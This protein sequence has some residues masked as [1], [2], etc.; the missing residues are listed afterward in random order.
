MKKKN[1]EEKTKTKPASKKTDNKKPAAPRKTRKKKTA[2][3][4]SFNEVLEIIEVSERTL[5]SWRSKDKSL[6]VIKVSG[7]LHFDPLKLLDWL[8]ITSREDQAAKLQGWLKAEGVNAK[9]KLKPVRKKRTTSVKT[10]KE[11]ETSDP[12]TPGAFK[13]SFRFDKNRPVDIFEVK[14]MTGALLKSMT[15]ELDGSDYTTVAINSKTLATLAEGYRKIEASC[16]E[17]DE[18]LKNVIPIS[19]VEK[20]HGEILTRVKTDI[21]ALPFAIADRIATMK[22]P[23]KIA[24]LLKKEI[25][26][27]LRHLAEDIDADTILGK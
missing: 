26:D 4:L 15:A 18:Q 20:F 17:I 19:A 9:P 13:F 24:E 25:D 27:C 8:V 12:K 23:E 6:P 1:T 22:S 2:K 11:K 14:R 21:R 7:R 5:K 16:I 10:Q 3:S